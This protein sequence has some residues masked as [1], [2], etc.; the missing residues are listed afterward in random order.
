MGIL[1]VGPN[2]PSKQ[3]TIFPNDGADRSRMAGSPAFFWVEKPG[4]L[5]PPPNAITASFDLSLLFAH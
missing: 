5:A 1:L 3:E 4:C 2:R